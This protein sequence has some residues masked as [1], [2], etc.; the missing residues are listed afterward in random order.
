MTST[1]TPVE[2]VLLLTPRVFG[3]NRGW[4][5]ESYSA[6]ALAACGIAAEFIQDNRSYSAKKGTLRGLH[7]QIAPHVQ[8]KLFTCTRGAVFDVACDARK[9]S[10][11]YG[12]WFGAELT[13]ENK[14]QLWI[15]KGCL[16][17]F[18][19]LTDDVE[20]LYKV[21]APYAP[22]CERGVRFDD[23][24]FG[25]DWGIREPILSAKDLAAPCFAE[26]GADFTYS[27]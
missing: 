10:P 5:Y 26:S 3:D 16:H 9:G 12:K 1:T 20:V 24:F 13:A 15:P 22:D 27:R 4:F 21:D 23:P 18:V 6:K 8:G 19:T 25:V 17:G 11:T 2:G 14:K 7:C